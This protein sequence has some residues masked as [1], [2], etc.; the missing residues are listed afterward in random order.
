MERGT[1]FSG[2]PRRWLLVGFACSI[3]SVGFALAEGNLGG[4]ILFALMAVFLG[5]RAATKR[6]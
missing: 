2:L 5:Y 6:G 4:L 3:V 1:G